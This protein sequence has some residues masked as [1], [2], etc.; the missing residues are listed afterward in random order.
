MISRLVG[1]LCW[2]VWVGLGGLVDWWVVSQSVGWSGLCWLV[3]WW[4]VSQSVGWV[5]VLV[6]LDWVGWVG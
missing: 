3:D 4:V 1:L 2:L 6:S 5:V